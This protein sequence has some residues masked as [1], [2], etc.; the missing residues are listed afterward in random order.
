MGNI[1]PTNRMADDS[2]ART[3]ERTGG[4]PETAAM[5]SACG[6][7]YPVQE[8]DEGDLRPVGT[9]GTCECG[10][11]EFEYAGLE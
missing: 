9:D 4:A 1:A 10:N 7:V 3:G 8:T 6:N 11:D 5:C 2:D